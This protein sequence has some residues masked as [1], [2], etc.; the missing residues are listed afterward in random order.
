MGCIYH[1][2]VVDAFSSDAIP[3]H[4]ITREAIEMYFKHLAKE[5]ILCM[6]T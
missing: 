1:M 2:M 4:L 3:A 5:G 6:H